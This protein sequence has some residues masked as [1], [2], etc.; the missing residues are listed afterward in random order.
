M[1]VLEETLT[2]LQKELNIRLNLKDLSSKSR[3]KRKTRKKLLSCARM[4]IVVL[5]SLA[6]AYKRIYKIDKYVELCH[7]ANS[8][9]EKLL[10]KNDNL[11][12]TMNRICFQELEKVIDL[13]KKLLFLISLKN[14]YLS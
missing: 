12:I 10:A 3:E 2:I 14:I 1:L 13:K 9:A 8:I 6:T 5:M 11:R 7:L 4:M